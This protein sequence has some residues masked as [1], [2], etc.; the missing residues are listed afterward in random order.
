M[1]KR[2]PPS[3][4]NLTKPRAWESLAVG[5]K[6]E[7]SVDLGEAY[8]RETRGSRKKYDPLGASMFRMADLVISSTG[9]EIVG[10]LTIK[11]PTGSKHPAR[12][13][14]IRDRKA[15]LEGPEWYCEHELPAR[16]P[17]YAN[18]ELGV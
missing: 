8:Q 7:I 5:E 15:W 11:D 18:F 12:K 17:V 13:C 3:R 10:M 14:V 16:M 9:A 2:T 1:E 6:V 4:K